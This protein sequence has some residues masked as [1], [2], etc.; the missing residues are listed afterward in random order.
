MAD[1]PATPIFAGLARYTATA[2]RAARVL[3]ASLVPS[4]APFVGLDVSP[5]LSD[6]SDRGSDRHRPASRPI[7]ADHPVIRP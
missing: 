4:A 7:E 5:G 2:E 1:K 6:L 3:L